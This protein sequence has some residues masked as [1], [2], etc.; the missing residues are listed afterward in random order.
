M[1]VG[2]QFHRIIVALLGEAKVCLPDL[3]VEDVS[4]RRAED[5]GYSGHHKLLC[6][7]SPGSI[8]SAPCWSSPPLILSLLCQQQPACLGQ[9]LHHFPSLLSCW[10][11]GEML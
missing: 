3:I 11:S 6:L 9:F 4:L 8:F 5:V 2:R 1:L 10:W 7:I